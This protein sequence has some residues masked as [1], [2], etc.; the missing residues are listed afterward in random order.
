MK[1]NKKQKID[2]LKLDLGC[3][4]NKKEGYIGVDKYNFQG[5]DIIL[6]L[7]KEDWPWEN[8]SIDEVNCTNLINHLTNFENKHERIHFFNELYRVIKKESKV[9][10]SIPHWCSMR[11]YGDPTNC[12]PF[13]ELGF[14]YLNEEWR[15]NNA[16]HTDIKWNENGYKCNFEATWGYSVRTDLTDK[17]KEEM[18][19]AIRSEKE[20]AQDIIANLVKLV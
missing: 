10:L 19:K 7:G 1:K 14:F 18:E 5:V 9:N 12:E 3:G 16:P 17:E 4:A 2:P 6:D 8:E 20:A 11:Y 13:S 15:K